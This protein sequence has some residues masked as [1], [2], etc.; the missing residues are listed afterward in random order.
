MEPEEIVLCMVMAG[1]QYMTAGFHGRYACKNRTE[2]SS[3]F[4]YICPNVSI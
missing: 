2:G 4:Y 1:K 3:I